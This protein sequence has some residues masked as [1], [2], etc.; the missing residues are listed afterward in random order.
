M[1]YSKQGMALTEQFESCR[2][3]SYQDSRG[4]WTIGWGH[5]QG[6]GPGMTCTQAQAD[7]WLLADVQ[8]AVNA[9]NR[10]VK[11]GLTQEE[12][13][14]LVDFV[15]N[16]G[17]GNFERSTMLRLL[18]DNDVQGAIDE[19]GK[20]DQCDGKVVAGLLRR[21][22]AEKALFALGADFSKDPASGDPAPGESQSQP[23]QVT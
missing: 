19:F 5:T 16:C 9:V 12:F 2:L 15:F 14:A 23:E 6:V 7:A 1:Q 17:V 18:N 10:L 20:W 21:R 11:G 22:D 4:I 8:D 13:D 3:E